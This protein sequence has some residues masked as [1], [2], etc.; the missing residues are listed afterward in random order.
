MLLLGCAAPGV[1][2][3][4]VDEG[5]AP[6]AGA[7]LRLDEVVTTDADGLAT[8]PVARPGLW[9]VEAED[10]LP[11]PLAVGAASE[12]LELVL[13]AAEGRFVIHSTGDV[14]MGRR[15]L[16]PTE[17]EPLLDPTDGATAEALVE[18]IAPALS[19]A[20]LVTT[21]LETVVGELPDADAYPGKRWL[22]Q[23]PPAALDAFGPMGVRV[24]GLANNHQR[25][26]LDAGV[27]S[28][29]SA[30]EA[31]GLD[32]YGGGRDAEEA[33]APAWVEGGP[34]VAL[35][36]Y[37]SVDGDWVNDQ[38]PDD[39]EALPGIV[40]EG[41]AFKWETRSWGAEAYGIPVAERRIGGAWR[42]VQA[43]I[44]DLPG[45]DQAR[46]WASVSAVWP[47]LQ[48][49][50]ARRGHGGGQAWSD[51]APAEIAAARAEADLVVV[52]LHMG[53]QFASAP[54]EA[55]VEAAHAA[56]EA[57]ADLVVC[58]HPHVLQ[59]LE[60][61]QGHLIAYSLGNFLFDQDFLSTFRSAFLR[62]VW[63][64]GSL[65]QARIVPTMLDAYRPVPVVDR[66]ATDVGRGLWEASLAGA[67]AMRGEDLAVRAV[68]TE[69]GSLAFVEEHGSFRV[70][71][72]L[73]AARRTRFFIPEGDDAP[74]RL[75]GLVQR[76]LPVQVG[77]SLGAYGRFED[78]DGD[79]LVDEAPGWTWSGDH[80]FLDRERPLSGAQSLCLYREATHQD[81]VSARMTARIPLPEHR[82]YADAEGLVPLD[83]DA[84]YSI[85]LLAR[86]DGWDPRPSLRVAVYH[87]DDL[88]PTEDP[89]STL[90]REVE[91]PLEL[92]PGGT[93]VLRVELDDTV[94]AP[95]GE[96][97]ANALLLYVS[98]DPPSVFDT[99]LWVDDVE[100]IEWRDGAAEPP[101]WA[102][103]DWLRGDPGEVEVA[104][105]PW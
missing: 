3:R 77:R 86:Y 98:L 69:P 62:T 31:A 18:D 53:Y 91:L 90:L 11:E 12:E 8:L 28:T 85:R 41:D 84:S 78:E 97:R 104:W 17:G 55:V 25:D 22:L 27:A 50:V 29:L 51:A 105:L 4:V 52:N 68:A 56:V 99:W 58:H 79:A 59:G 13:L 48:D 74:V 1:P 82:L 10:F 71:P 34:R 16:A 44:D 5:G 6:V 65:L 21:N 19:A 7:E 15:Y 60:F 63:E 73:P 70:L 67:V 30:L 96:L 46:L 57:G 2:V 81:R 40:P 92:A 83:G 61:H 45:A 23:T 102:A 100:L 72:E 103:I 49:W 36:A 54:G 101:G 89:E 47:E 38:Y 88:D 75:P 32:H 95:L 94:L 43:V 37:T 33:A 80:V 39:D 64:G 87:F 9:M 24:V 93:Q 35:L 76:D 26:W 42:A 14:M 66:L 20:D